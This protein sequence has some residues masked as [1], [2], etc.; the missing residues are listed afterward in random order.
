MSTYITV[1]IPYVNTDPHL[2][3]AYE[4]IEADLAARAR[5]LLGESVRFLGG[6]DEYSLKNVLAAEASGETT[7]VFVNRHADAFAALAEPL[8]ISFDDFIRTSCDPRHRPAVDRLWRACARRG[9]LYKR[10][11]TGS[12]CVGCEQFYDPAEL[13][14]GRCPDH[15]VSVET[16]TEP[17]WFFRLSAY[18]DHLIELVEPMSCAS[19]R[20]RSAL[21]SWRSCVEG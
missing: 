20:R 9:D 4:L 6:T 7:Q 13:V 18:T 19:R 15:D 11:Y 14:E 3:Y 1:A 2:G 5:R 8:G 17:N 10:D 16:V 12:Y 21:R